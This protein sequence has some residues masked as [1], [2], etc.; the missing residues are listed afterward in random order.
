MLQIFRCLK[1]G[2]SDLCDKKF[3]KGYFMQKHSG[4]EK[5][6][7]LLQVVERLGGCSGMLDFMGWFCSS[8]P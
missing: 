8:L 4:S 6:V 1:G 3:T 5:S 7:Y 2:Y